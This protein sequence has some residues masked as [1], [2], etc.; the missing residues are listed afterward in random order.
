[1]NHLSEPEIHEFL[2]QELTD[3]QRA[4]IEAHLSSCAECGARLGEIRSIFNMLS[5]LP[6]YPLRRDLS[7]E[8]RRRLS[9]ERAAIW[10]PIFAAQLGIVIG[11]LISVLVSASNVLSIPA[12]SLDAWLR[13]FPLSIQLGPSTLQFATLNAATMLWTFIAPLPAILS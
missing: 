12:I 10:N 13:P 2:D 6:E 7:G 3:Q 1:M 4:R 11:T 5:D 9:R 8:V